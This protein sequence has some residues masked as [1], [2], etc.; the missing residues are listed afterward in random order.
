MRTPD[1]LPLALTTR[2]ELASTG[3]QPVR[4]TRFVRER[5]LVVRLVTPFGTCLGVATRNYLGG[6]VAGLRP[7]AFGTCPTSRLVQRDRKGSNLL[8]RFWRPTRT[9]AHPFPYSDWWMASTGLGERGGPASQHRLLGT[10]RRAP[11][12]NRT[13]AQ[14]FAGPRSS[15]EL[16]G[17]SARL[18]GL[19][20]G[21]YYQT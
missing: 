5:V 19:S 18:S 1:R 14:A 15:A 20:R 2:I 16:R 13:W 6:P 3:R 4:F 21:E 10:S 7:H 12:R 17:H 11:S 9:P 8:S